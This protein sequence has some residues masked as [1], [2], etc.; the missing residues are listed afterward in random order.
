MKIEHFATVFG[1]VMLT[2]SILVFPTGINLAVLQS[3]NPYKEQLGIF[4]H[5]IND[6]IAV[7][8]GILV[9]VGIIFMIAESKKP[10]SDYKITG[11]STERM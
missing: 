9:V 10:Q 2:L 1:G 3:H 7:F 6:M 4:A 5:Q 11:T 8:S